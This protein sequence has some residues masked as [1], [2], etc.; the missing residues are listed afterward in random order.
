MYGRQRDSLLVDIESFVQ[1]LEVSEEGVWL[2]YLFNIRTLHLPRGFP[3]LYNLASLGYVFVL[4]QP[5]WYGTKMI[6]H[7]IKC[8]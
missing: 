5:T 8:P 7:A 6:I 4:E 2:E 3:W 1:S